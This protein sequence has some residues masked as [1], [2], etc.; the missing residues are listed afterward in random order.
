MAMHLQ[1]F[2]CVLITQVLYIPPLW[3]HQVTAVTDSVSVSVWSPYAA[4]ELY[5]SAIENA[6]LPIKASWPSTKRVGALRLLLESL[7]TSLE[8]NNGDVTAAEFIHWALLENRFKHV[9][10]SVGGFAAPADAANTVDITYC[11]Q[12]EREDELLLEA[13]EFFTDGLRKVVGIF[14]EI[15]TVAGTPRRDTYLANYL[16]LAV[17]S[18]VG[19]ANTKAFLTAMVEC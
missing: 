4:S 3:F 1:L 6:P 17:Y 15:L 19:V 5:S 13:E 9:G 18:V 8:L 11:W 16:E 7:V 12:R 10:G 14:K 2:W